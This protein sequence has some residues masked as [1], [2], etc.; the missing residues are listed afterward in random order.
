MMQASDDEVFSSDVDNEVDTALRQLF[1]TWVLQV[2]LAQVLVPSVIE[3]ATLLLMVEVVMAK[4]P[5]P[6][7]PYHCHGYS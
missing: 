1:E 7:P 5:P 3:V 2:E 6:P 4:T